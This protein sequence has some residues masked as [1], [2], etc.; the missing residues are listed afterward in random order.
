MT[1]GGAQQAARI[2][3]PAHVA[4]APGLA[5]LCRALT[6]AGDE[7]GLL[8][9]DAAAIA[10]AL[11]LFG[12]GFRHWSMYY[13]NAVVVPAAAAALTFDRALPLALGGCRLRLDADGTPAEVRLRA[14]DPLGADALDT[15][16]EGHLVPFVA[17]YAAAT[18]L[19]PR[20]L[21]SNAAVTLAFALDRVAG[22]ALPGPRNAVAALLGG[23]HAFPHL[24]GAF[25]EDEM[26]ERER[27]LCCGRR[28][29]SGVAPCYTL[30]PE[31]DVW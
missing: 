26:G 12:R 8:P 30:C 7:E 15:L 31:R 13:L 16:V 28:R 10:S 17:L 14:D 1:G 20:L 9:F 4:D 3:T 24:T 19:P 18:G 5:P 22:A 27:L 23:G 29:L 21:W 25:R 6:V 11:D 2:G